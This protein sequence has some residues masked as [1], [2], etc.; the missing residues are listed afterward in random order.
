MI[1]IF[2]FRE[3]KHRRRRLRDRRSGNGA[4]EKVDN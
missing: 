1:E 3:E 2:V 4:F